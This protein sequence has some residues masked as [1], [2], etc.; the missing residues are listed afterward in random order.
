MYD[1]NDLYERVVKKPAHKQKHSTQA[2]TGTEQD[3]WLLQWQVIHVSRQQSTP[4][5]HTNTTMFD[6]Y[7]VLE[8]PCLLYAGHSGAHGPTFDSS[9]HRTSE[10]CFLQ[11]MFHLF[12]TCFL[13]CY[14]PMTPIFVSF[15][16]W[17]HEHFQLIA[18]IITIITI[19]FVDM[20]LS[21]SQSAF[22]RLKGNL[23]QPPPMCSI[24][25]HHFVPESS[26]H[27]S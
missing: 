13:P 2:F 19:Y 16:L 6:W 23:P 22:Q 7:N 15:L 24:H 27:I 21:H 12:I 4:H 1:V 25:S 14:P 9:V 8:M 5:H 18:I 26:P 10:L 11:A 20:A 3:L 17:S